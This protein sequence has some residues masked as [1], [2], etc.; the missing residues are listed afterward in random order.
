MLMQTESSSES[1]RHLEVVAA[2]I[3]SAGMPQKQKLLQGHYR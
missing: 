1:T 2:I 3:A